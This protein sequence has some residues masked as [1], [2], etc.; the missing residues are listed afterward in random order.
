M[1]VKLRALKQDL[2]V[3]NTE[4][5]GNVSTK[6]LAALFQLGFWD[7]KKREKSLSMEEREVRRRV[8]EDFKNWAALEEISWRQ[9]SRE[10]WQ[11]SKKYK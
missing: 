3:W 2:R 7:A 1:A 10:L 6:K 4:V 8:V 9:K 11:L 5:F